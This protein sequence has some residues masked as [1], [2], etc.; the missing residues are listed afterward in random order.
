MSDTSSVRARCALQ[1]AYVADA[2]A[3]GFHWLYDQAQI[4]KLAGDAP[5]FR[6]PNE[7]DYT[8]GYFAHDGKPAGAPSQY[9][10]Q[11]KAMADALAQSGRY[12]AAIYAQT[13]RDTFGYGGSWVGYTDRPTRETLDN[14]ARLGDP[15]APITTC[16][17]DDAQLPALSKRP[18]LIVAHHDDPN[19]MSHVETAV[20]VTNNRD[21]SVAWGQAFARMLR[22]ALRGATQDDIIKAAAQNA[23]EHITAQISAAQA[24]RAQSSAALAQ[25]HGL[26][27]QLQAAFTV[28]THII[29]SAKDYPTAVRTNILA[30]GDNCGRA[31]PI[32][33]ILGAYFAEDTAKSIPTDWIARTHLAS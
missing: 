12:D 23:P 13:F 33:A 21:D 14:M 15:D 30:G 10:A 6:T 5:E 22:A 16:G 8:K 4:A 32:G 31:I 24:A 20:R 27:C 29:M 7:P 3:L 25:T 18:P 9:G 2:A 1:G 17:A 26:H 11:M 28:I 19:L